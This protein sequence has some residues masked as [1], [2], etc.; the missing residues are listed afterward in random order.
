MKRGPVSNQGA[1]LHLRRTRVPQPAGEDWI[2]SG[3]HL[4][5]PQEKKKP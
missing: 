5:E 3:A 4:A 2:E 1:H